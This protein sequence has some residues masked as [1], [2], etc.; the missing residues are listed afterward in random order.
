MTAEFGDN[1]DH[2]PDPDEHVGGSRINEPL[3]AADIS[4]V[5]GVALTIHEIIAKVVGMKA[6][7]LT[8]EEIMETFSSQSGDLS[9]LPEDWKITPDEVLR[10]VEEHEREQRN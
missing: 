7:P 3:N 5:R 4:S 6:E 9:E 8:V 1:Q 2:I 10:V